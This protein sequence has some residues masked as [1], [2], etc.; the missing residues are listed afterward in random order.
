MTAPATLTMAPAAVTAITTEIATFGQLGVETGGFLLAPADSRVVTVVAFTATVGIARHRRLLEISP[1]A[2]ARL[3]DYADGRDL[4]V[5]AQFHS[6]EGTAFLSYTDKTHG[7]RVD[8]FTSVVIPAF[9]SPPTDPA[10]WG[11]WTF[12]D[13]DWTAICPAVLGGS[14]V[15]LIRFDEDGTHAH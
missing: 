11:W 6:H 8:G 12:H 3:F 5:P 2:L 7:L 14:D 4:R 13:Y 1:G 9:A 15:Q 10:A